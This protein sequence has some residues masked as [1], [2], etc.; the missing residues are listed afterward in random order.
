[1]L[2]ALHSEHAMKWYRRNVGDCASATHDVSMLQ[3]GADT[4]FSEYYVATDKLLPDN[5]MHVHSIAHAK[6]AAVAF[7]IGK[8][9]VSGDDDDRYDKVIE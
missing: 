1:M 6:K 4:L 5:P 2:A 7:V 8:F 3:H 9:F